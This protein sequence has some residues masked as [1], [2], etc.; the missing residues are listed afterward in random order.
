MKRATSF[1]G[2]VLALLMTSAWMG[3]EPGRSS[4]EPGSIGGTI[5]GMDVG[6]I[7]VLRSFDK[8][9]LVNVA[10]SA[11]DSAGHFILTPESPLPRGYHQLWSE[12]SAVLTPMP[13]KE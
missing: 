13:L 10:Q 7:V 9:N 11:L 6:S 12:I 4:T 5:L 8:G 1:L 3:C 2:I